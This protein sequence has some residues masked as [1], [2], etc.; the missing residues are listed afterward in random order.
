MKKVIAGLAFGT[1]LVG[2][3]SFSSFENTNN[4]AIQKVT[5]LKIEVIQPPY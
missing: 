3:L 2:V 5:P 1:I 4:V